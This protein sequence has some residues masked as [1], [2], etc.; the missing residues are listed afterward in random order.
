V[1]I[2]KSGGADNTEGE[3]MKKYPALLIIGVALLIFGLRKSSILQTKWQ[4]TDPPRQGQVEEPVIKAATPEDPGPI[5]T[6]V[7][8][9]D[10]LK[11]QADVPDTKPS[12]TR[13]PVAIDHLV[14][15]E[16]GK[17]KHLLHNVFS[18]NR[19]TQF[20]FMIPAHQSNAKL[21]GTFRSFTKRNDPGSSDRSADVD[22]LLLN[23]E[24]FNQFQHGEPQSVTYELNSA[25]N[26]MVDWWIPATRAEAKT[27]HLVFINSADDVKLKFV[28]ADFTLNF[29]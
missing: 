5:A 4:K 2:R 17:P 21:H 6:V 14:S 20:A 23:D 9:L 26:Q 27:Y 7:V 15:I 19:R 3:V 24:E 28:Q 10:V 12:P 18:V 1:A 11:K 16:P 29:E 8:P 22:L 13:E 25:H